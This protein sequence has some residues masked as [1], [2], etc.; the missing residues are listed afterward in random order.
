MTLKRELEDLNA[1]N[2]ILRGCKTVNSP[3]FL[4]EAYPL[5][6]ALA[7]RDAPRATA[8]GEKVKGPKQATKPRMPYWT[9]VS[10]DGIDIRVGRTSSDN[11]SVSC[12]PKCRDSRDWWMQRRGARIARRHSIHGG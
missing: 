9:F 11:D 3:K 4:E 7:V 2:D 5:A 10:A 1:L 12:D 6:T 8:E